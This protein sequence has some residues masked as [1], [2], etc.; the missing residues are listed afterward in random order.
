MDDCDGPNTYIA[1]KSKIIAEKVNTAILT[2]PRQYRHQGTDAMQCV[3]IGVQTEQ[4]S[5]SISNT[6]LKGNI[7]NEI[8]NLLL[9][10]VKSNNEELNILGRL[11]IFHRTDSV[12]LSM[13]KQYQLSQKENLPLHSIVCGPNERIAFLFASKYHKT[14]C[15]HNGTIAL[16]QRY[17]MIEHLVLSS[18]PTILRYGP[19]GLIAVG[20]VTGHILIIL[21]GEILSINEAHTLSVTSLEWLYHL[22]QLISVSLDGRIIIHKL[23]ST[24]LEVK[25][26]KLITALNL[27][28]NIRKSNLS[29]KYIGLTSLFVIKDR[30][31]IGSEIGAVWI[32]TIPNLTITLLHYEIDCIE[33]VA[34]ISNYTIITTTSHKGLIITGNGTLTRILDIPIQSVSIKNAN[35]IICGSNEQI[36]AIQLD[37][38]KILMK[39]TF[40]YEAFTVVPNDDAL[41]VV[42]KQLLVTLYRININQ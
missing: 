15:S 16:W 3:S 7:S 32:V 13:I 6:T 19:H 37:D 9:E 10:T 36:C 21:N 5:S 42:D 24:V 4:F 11:N 28:R 1:T 12:T 8:L 14:W 17:T 27:P 40:A 34:Y 26:S 20:L 25:Y 23:K 39:Q 41:I 33:T 35:L 18:C 38:L 22:Q 31:I 2:D 29:T 30:L